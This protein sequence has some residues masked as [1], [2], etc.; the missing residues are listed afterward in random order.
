MEHTKYKCLERAK[1]LIDDGSEISL[2]YAALELRFCMEAITYEKLRSSAR[3]IPPDVLDKWQP[4]QAVKALLEHEP[5]SD[6]GFVLYAGVEE[7]YGKPSKDMRFVGEHKAF[8]LKW[9]RKHYNKVGKLLHYPHTQSGN[10]PTS[11][12]QLKEYLS[13]VASEIDEVLKGNIL[14]G[15]L[16]QTFQFECEVCYQLIVYGKHTLEN[17]G[18]VEC[19]NPNCRAEYFGALSE[20]GANATFQ[21]K[22]TKF[23]CAQCGGEIPVENRHIKIGLE[24]SCPS[25]STKHRIEH[26]QWGYSAEIEGNEES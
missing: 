4:P 2:R 24:F 13:I 6:K 9:L 10:Q 8:D 12:K 11:V 15:W 25:C 21:L 26:K 22:V 3:H 1:S 20:D 18:H 14:G 5:K 23:D 7:E 16:D 17:S 19:Q